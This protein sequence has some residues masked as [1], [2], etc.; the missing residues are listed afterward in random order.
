MITE[1]QNPKT[2][3]LD[4]LSTLDLLRVMNEEDYKVALAVQEAIPA[5]AKAVDGMVERKQQGGRIIYMGAGTSGRLGV[6]DA[7]ECVPT[8][9]THPDEVQGL[10]AGGTGAMLKAVEG[11]ED[12]REFA[13]NDLIKTGITSV[14]VVIGIAASGFT[15]YVLEGVALAKE[16]G[17]FTVGIACN[18]PSPLLDSVEV[19]IPL[20][21]GAEI[22]TGSTRLKAGTAQ[23]LALNML[24]TALMVKM[25]KVYGNLMVDVQ[26]T[27]QK[28]ADRA[29]R[30]VIQVSGVDQATAKALLKEAGGSAKL[31]IVIAMKGLSLSDARL[32]LETHKGNLR[33]VIES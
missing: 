7:V 20:I 3:N 15:P 8:F 6:L 25:G 5:I 17:C 28:L 1:Q 27:N 2:A 19:A 24:S 10:M 18:A 23:K 16:R 4:A 26:I 11:A 9:G 14:D 29:E 30:I 33:R 21:V 32:A 22:L 13:R 31:A 12:N